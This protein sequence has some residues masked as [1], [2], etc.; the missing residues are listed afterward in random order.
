MHELAAIAIELPATATPANVVWTAP[1]CTTEARP[2]SWLLA[3]STK[4][5]ILV[6]AITIADSITGI[7]WSILKSEE[8]LVGVPKGVDGISIKVKY[9]NWT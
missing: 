4:R 8:N 2:L 7:R 1:T 6:W 3:P 9:I 5:G